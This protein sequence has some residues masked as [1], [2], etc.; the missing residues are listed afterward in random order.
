MHKTIYLKLGLEDLSW[1]DSNNFFNLLMVV[2]VG[3]LLLLESIFNIHKCTS[4]NW[5]IDLLIDLLIGWLV[6][7][8]LIAWL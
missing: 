5:L 3:L 1:N 8:W 7:Y 2:S 6:G 4:T